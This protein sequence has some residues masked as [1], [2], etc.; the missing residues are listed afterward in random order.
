LSLEQPSFALS[1]PYRAREV[2]LVN[3][4]CKAPLVLLVPA[5]PMVLP[6]MMVPR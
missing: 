3:V 1:F 4:V 2:F 6:A 5:D